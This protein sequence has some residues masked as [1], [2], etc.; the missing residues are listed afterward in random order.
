MTIDAGDRQT[1]AKPIAI[2]Q[3]PNSSTAAIA[4]NSPASPA[5]S[6]AC[7]P[8]TLKAA[9]T[10]A[11]ASHFKRAES[12]RYSSIGR[13]GKELSPPARPSRRGQPS[14]AADGVRYWFHRPAPPC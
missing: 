6:A 3:S 4:G 8:P 10:P 14:D 5:P 1:Q 13:T 11:T 9:T 7:A 12:I 2:R